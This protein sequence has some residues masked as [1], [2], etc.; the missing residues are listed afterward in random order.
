MIRYLL[1]SILLISECLFKDVLFDYLKTRG[2]SHNSF[3]HNH[4][5]PHIYLLCSQLITTIIFYRSEY[6]P[7]MPWSPQYIYG[8][9]L[10]AH[11]YNY[12]VSEQFSFYYMC[13]LVIPYV[14]ISRI[15]T[16]LC[17]LIDTV[18]H[19]MYLTILSF[20]CLHRIHSTHLSAYSL[21]SVISHLSVLEK[22]VWWWLFYTPANVNLIFH[23]TPLFLGCLYMITQSPSHL[24][25]SISHTLLVSLHVWSQLRFALLSFQC[26]SQ[27]IFELLLSMHYIHHIKNRSFD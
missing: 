4:N 10:V 25:I 9:H 11:N 18:L 5:R 24:H 3:S 17:S 16:N 26:L 27:L 19:L 2:W 13:T 6:S 1:L 12:I 23:T 20:Y 14:S 15:Y 21:L 22:N 8:Y 7:T